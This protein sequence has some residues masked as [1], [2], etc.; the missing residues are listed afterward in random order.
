MVDFLSKNCSPD[1]WGRSR[2]IFFIGG[3]LDV[4]QVRDHRE[5]VF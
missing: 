2:V 3:L 5:G 4:F 1:K